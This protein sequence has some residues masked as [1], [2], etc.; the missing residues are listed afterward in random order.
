MVASS[1]RIA[2]LDPQRANPDDLARMASARLH[3]RDLDN[4][5]SFGLAE[6]DRGNHQQAYAVF[7]AISRER[8]GYRE[9]DDLMRMTRERLS[10]AA[11]PS[12]ARPRTWPFGRPGRRPARRSAQRGP[13]ADTG[14][15]WLVVGGMAV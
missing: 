1:Q 13:L 8:P 14:S 12:P 3:E 4:R 15:I 7:E 9:V 10:R 6:L 11:A 5:Y 2:Q